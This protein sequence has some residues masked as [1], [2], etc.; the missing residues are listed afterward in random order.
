MKNHRIIGIILFIILF[1]NSCDLS[2]LTGNK[3]K[4][5]AKKGILDLREW[6]FNK[7][8][9]IELDGEWEFYWEKLYSLEEIHSIIFNK[10][11]IHLPHSWN[12]KIINGETIGS[13]GYAT[14]RLKILLPPNSPALA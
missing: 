9:P 8:G 2:N 7:Y 1:F 13:D 5:L 11:Y 3:N 4:T 14:F 6:D 10:E 12:N